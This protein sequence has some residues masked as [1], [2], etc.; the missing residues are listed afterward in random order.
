MIGLESP[1]IVQARVFGVSASATALGFGFGPVIGGASAAEAGL[2]T[3]L[4]LAAVLAI[5]VAI[6]LAVRGREPA[7]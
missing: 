1:P 4:G 3:G 5:L 2:T 7:R 6:V